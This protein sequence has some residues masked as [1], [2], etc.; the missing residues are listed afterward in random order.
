MMG[1]PVAR[2]ARDGSLMHG[3]CSKKC[4]AGFLCDPECCKR[5]ALATGVRSGIRL[6]AFQVAKDGDSSRSRPRSIKTCAS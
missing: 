6:R 3:D 5:Q 1:H 2:V 4:G